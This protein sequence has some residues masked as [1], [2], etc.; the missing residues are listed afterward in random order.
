LIG[1][2]RLDA[3]AARPEARD[4][5]TFMH[6]HAEALRCARQCPRREHRVGIACPRQPQ[7]LLVA[8]ELG[9]R[10]PR[11]QRADIQNFKLYPELLHQVQVSPEIRLAEI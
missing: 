11:P 3:R 6:L 4:L 9:I 7:A 1:L 2:D 5:H 8:A 10:H